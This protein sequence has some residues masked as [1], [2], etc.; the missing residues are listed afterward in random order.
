MAS[1]E[2]SP[3]SVPSSP[4]H[5]DSPNTDL[6]PRPLR[7]PPSKAKTALDDNH[8]AEDVSHPFPGPVG[9]GGPS[10]AGE[11]EPSP[12]MS[13]TA[14][15][16]LRS[17]TS[18]LGSLVSRFEILDAVSNADMSSSCVPRPS[19]NQSAT[20]PAIVTRLPPGKLVT[21]TR[22]QSPTPSQEKSNPVSDSSE[23]SPRQL[24]MPK[25]LAERSQ[26]P[27]GTR[28][29]TGI[30]EETL[31]RSQGIHTTVYQSLPV[32]GMRDIS[33]EC[34][35]VKLSAHHAYSPATKSTG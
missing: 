20:Q 28:V 16:Q 34:P 23:L 32:C 26:P 9:D 14:S 17:K 27:T 15:L 30:E 10:R 22:I 1:A 35:P 33:S 31:G 24:G 21:Q 25:L 7:L 8:R 19:W 5:F 6:R 11:E 12:A 4:V 13:E 3:C 2:T 18:K 29:Q